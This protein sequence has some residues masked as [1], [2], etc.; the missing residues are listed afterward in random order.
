MRLVVDETCVRELHFGLTEKI[1]VLERVPASASS[2]DLV[3]ASS[4]HPDSPI[5]NLRFG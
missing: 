4:A 3:T 1:S 2:S 5:E